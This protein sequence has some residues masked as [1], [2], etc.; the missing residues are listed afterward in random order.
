MKKRSLGITAVLLLIMGLALAGHLTA[1]PPAQ[2]CEDW[3]C[4]GNAGCAMGASDVTD[5]QHVLCKGGG[6]A[7]CT[8]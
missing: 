6:A 8:W 5:C 1:I 2:W 4:H 7:I 3:G